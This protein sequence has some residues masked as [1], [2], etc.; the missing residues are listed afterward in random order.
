MRNYA[1]LGDIPMLDL[2]RSLPL[3]IVIGLCL[4]IP[5][6]AEMG[7]AKSNE[8]KSPTVTHPSR[9]ET[10]PAK[11]LQPPISFSLPAKNEVDAHIDAV[12]KT[13]GSRKER[14]IRLGEKP[15][16]TSSR[17]AHDLIDK[18]RQQIS[19]NSAMP[20]WAPRYYSE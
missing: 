18:Q 9:K 14:M 15:D 11:P 12:S 17:E 19:P 6:S 10:S 8:K 2:F 20:N 13:V 16:H 5:L 4:S 1:T 3:Q 7:Q